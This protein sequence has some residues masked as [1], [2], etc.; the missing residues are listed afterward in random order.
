MIHPNVGGAPPHLDNSKK[1]YI[2]D[3]AAFCGHNRSVRIAMLGLL[4]AHGRSGA[5]VAVEGAELNQALRDHGL[6]G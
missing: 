4:E 6:D 5:L 1:Q 3:G 2:A